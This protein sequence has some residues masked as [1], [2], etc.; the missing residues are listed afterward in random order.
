[1]SAKLVSACTKP[2]QVKQLGISLPS[3]VGDILLLRTAAYTPQE[4]KI[5]SYWLLP[6]IDDTPVEP[7]KR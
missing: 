5:N 7:L 1:M 4:V 2:A 6:P 3:K